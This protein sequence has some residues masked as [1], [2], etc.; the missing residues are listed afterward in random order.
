[1]VLQAFVVIVLVHPI[2]YRGTHPSHTNSECAEP[3]LAHTPR[4]RKRTSYGK[5][6]SSMPRTTM[7]TTVTHVTH[8]RA[9]RIPSVIERGLALFR[10]RVAPS[11]GLK[12][13]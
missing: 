1:M 13:M 6:R 12:T 9:I 4:P 8:A 10:T 5:N 7:V 3:Q 2:A 11:G